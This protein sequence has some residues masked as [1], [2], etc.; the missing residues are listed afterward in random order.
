MKLSGANG[1]DKT[2]SAHTGGTARRVAVSRASSGAVCLYVALFTRGT[3]E[4][5]VRGFCVLS[6][7]PTAGN[8]A[9]DY[10][11]ARHAPDGAETHNAENRLPS[12]DKAL[13]AD[14]AKRGLR[15]A[16]LQRPRC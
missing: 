5:G 1:R 11:C 14:A 6:T 16:N 7:S 13:F 2:L 8:S 10:V 3:S 4:R 15:N 9:L 12:I